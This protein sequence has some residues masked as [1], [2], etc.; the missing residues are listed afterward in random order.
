MVV[1]IVVITTEASEAD[2]VELSFLQET[3]EIAE[4]KAFFGA[5]QNC[6]VEPLVHQGSAKVEKP[7][8]GRYDIIAPF[9]DRENE[10]NARLH[11]NDD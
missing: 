11:C 3:P 9:T 10:E 1:D 6:D 8:V 4:S 2:N 7:E 5:V